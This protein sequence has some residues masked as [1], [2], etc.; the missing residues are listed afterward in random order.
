MTL[1]R[2]TSD[3]ITDGSILNAD[4]HNSA[5]IAGSKIASDSITATQIANDAIT[6]NELANNSVG[7]SHIIDGTIF[8]SEIN[9][10]AA[11]AGSKIDTSTF[12]A[13]ITNTHTTPAI[14]FVENDANPDFRISNSGGV[15]R[16]EDITGGYA[17]KLAVNTDGHVDVVGNL[18]VGAGLDVTGNITCTGTIPAAQ[19]TGA[20]PAI[21]GSNLTG[22]TSTTI[23]ANGDNRLITGSGTANTLNGENELQFS[24]T[25]VTDRML[26]IG[27]TDSTTARW[28]STRQGLKISGTNPVIYGHTTTDS[29]GAYLGLSNGQVYLG[30]TENGQILFQTAGS[31][32]GTI[33]RWYVQAAG[34]FIP[35]SNNTYDIGT[36]SNRVRNIYTNDLHLSNEG[37]SNDVDGTWGDWTIQELSLI[38]I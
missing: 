9:G 17:T 36:T 6:A 2:V 12:T 31:G 13:P 35:A 10:S 38:H 20:L 25:S 32:T 19:L 29:K 26:L 37:S 30:A 7:N 33:N 28:S 18:D 4:L 11:I 3:G 16:V 5:A 1:T 24:N 15:L 34:H 23:N 27:T 22:V 14:N 21:D 8:N